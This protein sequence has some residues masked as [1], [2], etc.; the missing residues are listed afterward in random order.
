M[1]PVKSNSKEINTS[2]KPDILTESFQETICILKKEFINKENTIKNLPIALKNITS[3]TYKVSPSNK[4]SGKEPILENVSDKAKGRI[5][6]R[7][8]QEN[9]ARQV[10]RKTNIFYSLIRI[11]TLREVIE[12]NVQNLE[13]NEVIPPLNKVPSCEKKVN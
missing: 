5:S 4:E 3:N 13:L 12:S 10:F 7:V 11:R 8:F 2:N 1:S 9:K 6:K